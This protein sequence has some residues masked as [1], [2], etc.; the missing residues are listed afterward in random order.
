[1]DEITRLNNR[2]T[3]LEKD[4][5]ALKSAFSIPLEVDQALTGRGFLKIPVTV[6]PLVGSNDYYVATSNGGSPTTKITISNGLQIA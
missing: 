4:I 3:K 2:I 5:E 6:K 1:M